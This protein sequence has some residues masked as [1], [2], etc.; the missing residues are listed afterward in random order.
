MKA[1]NSIRNAQNKFPAKKRGKQ[2]TLTTVGGPIPGK[3]DRCALGRR[4]KLIGT[5]LLTYNFTTPTSVTLH[6]RIYKHVSCIFYAQPDSGCNTHHHHHYHHHGRIA[7]KGRRIVAP[8]C[9]RST[10]RLQS[11]PV[12]RVESFRSLSSHLFRGRPGGRRHVW[13]GGGL[14][15]T[16]QQHN[17]FVCISRHLQLRTGFC[18]CNVLLPACPC[19]RQPAHSDSLEFSTVLSTW[20][21]YRKFQAVSK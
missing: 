18:G 6:H 13:S 15:D 11:S 16:Q 17:R 21:P 2:H 9:P 19:W 12:G 20:F 8:P 7:S 3:M 5:H 4:M 10:A 14:S 1:L